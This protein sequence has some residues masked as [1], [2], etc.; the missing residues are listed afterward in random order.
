MKLQ[1]FCLLNLPK[2]GGKEGCLGELPFVVEFPG[3]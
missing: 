1:K 3:V 2:E